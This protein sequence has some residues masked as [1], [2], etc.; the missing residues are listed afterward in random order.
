MSGDVI[1]TVTLNAALHVAYTVGDADGEAITP[2][3][4]PGYRAGGRGVTAARRYRVDLAAY[5]RLLDAV[6]VEPSA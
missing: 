3:S 5:E 1:V 2:V 6:A 4:R